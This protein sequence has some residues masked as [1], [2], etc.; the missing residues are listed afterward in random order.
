MQTCGTQIRYNRHHIPLRDLGR[1][2]KIRQLYTNYYPN[3]WKH[4]FKSV[5]TFHP[6]VDRN[7]KMVSIIIK[8]SRFCLILWNILTK[9]IQAADF[10]LR[11][12]IALLSVDSIKMTKF[13][14]IWFGKIDNVLF[15][16]DINIRCLCIMFHIALLCMSSL[17]LVFLHHIYIYH[18]ST[19]SLYMYL[20][21]TCLIDD[22]Q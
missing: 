6:G 20:Y 2:Q 8:E 21:L 3:I 12:S 9:F 18:A 10:S 19:S 1:P 16:S 22:V 4:W 5:Q 13:A 11:S 7:T 15:E 14:K 17:Q